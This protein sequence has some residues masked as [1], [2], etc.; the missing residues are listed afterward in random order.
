[1][2]EVNALWTINEF[3]EETIIQKHNDL[4]NKKLD[5]IV[6]ET[7][8]CEYIEDNKIDRL[9]LSEDK[10]TYSINYQSTFNICF[11]STNKPQL[12][13][14]IEPLKTHLESLDLFQ[15]KMINKM[16]KLKNET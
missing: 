3:S 16:L 13:R 6:H 11:T 2:S 12:S 10:E 4:N 7:S 1:M 5:Q 9:I 8:K 15:Y 14:N